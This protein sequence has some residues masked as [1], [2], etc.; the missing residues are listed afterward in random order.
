[1]PPPA[2]SR[3]VVDRPDPRAQGDEL[4]R[5]L[6]VCRRIGEGLPVEEIL[7]EILTE[8]RR[9]TNAEGGAV[10]AVEQRRLRIVCCQNDARPDLQFRAAASEGH[11]PIR[12]A[13]GSNSIPIDSASLA[14]H[15][16][17]TGQTLRIDDVYAI[18]EDA[19]HRYNRKIDEST[20]YRCVSMLV[21]PLID[22]RGE[23]VGVLQMI[24]KRDPDGEI[25]PFT[26][27]DQRIIE[28]V[29]CIASPSVREAQVREEQTRAHLDTILR[30]ATA[31]EFR[32]GE[33]SDHLR[34]V[35][36]YCETIARACGHPREWAR[37]V[38]LASPM[39]DI[40]KLGVPDAVL[41]K[42]G[43][44][45]PEERAV[46][47]RHT[48]IGASILAEPKDDL[49]RMAERIART[50]HER[51][52]GAGYP[53]RLKAE[54]IPLEGRIVAVADVFDALTSKRVYKPAFDVD[55]SIRSIA[56][57]AG[58]QFDPLVVEGFLNARSEI[59]SIFEAFTPGDHH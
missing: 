25:A 17:A 50:H 42:P 56:D 1:M 45:T 24:N 48:T 35:G 57:A 19:P 26:A 51:W 23:T 30:L 55:E 13:I 52:D 20:G 16:A 38:L 31:A 22:A 15:A 8:A 10:F 7:S 5:L 40:G 32:D 14:G 27:R 21:A 49:M 6:Q 34:R 46:M 53:A 47:E 37:M 41:L 4:D 3:S 59:V 11:C 43:R 12:G 54:D 58:S 36:L 28:G 44:F 2:A 29:A 33:T 18:P 9:I 39:H